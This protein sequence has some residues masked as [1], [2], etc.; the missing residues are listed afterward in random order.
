MTISRI[1]S[2]IKNFSNGK[3][4]VMMKYNI[5]DDDDDDDIV[6][7]ANR[8]S[9]GM[10]DH[11]TLKNKRLQLLIELSNGRYV[12]SGFRNPSDDMSI[13]YMYGDDDDYSI[14]SFSIYLMDA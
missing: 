10:V 13:D 2:V 11:P 8:K 12:S 9:I 14:K 7:F 5:D 6:D 3:E 1:S 4:I